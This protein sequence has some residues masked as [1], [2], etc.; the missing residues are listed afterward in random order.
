MASSG[1]RN[2]EEGRKLLKKKKKVREDKINTMAIITSELFG[3]YFKT[4]KNSKYD[5]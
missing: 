2:S 4:R 5:Q 1:N 3:F